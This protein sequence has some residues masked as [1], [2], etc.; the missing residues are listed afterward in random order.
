MER[1]PLIEPENYFAGYNESIEDLKH[2]PKAIELDKLCYELFIHQEMGRRFIDLISEHY[3][4]PAMANKGS[5][6]YSTEV[7]WAEGFK[8]AFRMI[9]GSSR[10][11]QQRINAETK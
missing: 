2:N 9:I 6:N 1:N 8:D 5:P 3:L 4:L 11:H 7:V 10:A